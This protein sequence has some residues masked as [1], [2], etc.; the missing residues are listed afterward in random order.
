MPFLNIQQIA[1][2]Y[3][4]LNPDLNLNDNAYKLYT[5]EIN[6]SFDLAT[7]NDLKKLQEQILEE[8]K[9]A[10]EIIKETFDKAEYKLPFSTKIPKN[11]IKNAF[12]TT[13]GEIPIN[14]KFL[15]ES[16]S[17]QDKQA[18]FEKAY[19][20]AYESII[21]A[22]SD[23]Q[24]EKI[25]AALS[26]EILGYAL[27]IASKNTTWNGTKLWDEIQKNFPSELPPRNKRRPIDLINNYLNKIK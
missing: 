21:Q 3:L 11:E 4:G 1:F 10:V 26:A 18:I 13:F 6:I 17:E 22:Y 24:K 7:E 14:L 2:L 9:K 25:K 19:E 12:L 8:Y 27:A 16:E 5:H 23:N 15:F 20:K